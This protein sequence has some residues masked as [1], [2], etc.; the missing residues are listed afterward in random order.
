MDAAL[1]S[2]LLASELRQRLQLAT[3]LAEAVQLL[4]TATQSHSISLRPGKQ[5]VHSI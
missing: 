5:A 2:P 3:L 1:G 4:T